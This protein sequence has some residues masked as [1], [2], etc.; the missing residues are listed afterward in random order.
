MGAVLVVRAAPCRPTAVGEAVY[1]HALQVQLLEHDLMT[2]IGPAAGPSGRILPVATNADS[3][4]TWLI[5]ALDELVSS[6]GVRVDVRV[7][8]EDRTAEWLRSGAVL[9]A[10]TSDDRPVQGCRSWPL[11]AMRYR[12]TT[13]PKV[14]ARLPKP[15]ALESWVAV[16]VFGFGTHDRLTERFLRERLGAEQQP[17]IRHHLPSPHAIVQ[18]CERGLGWAMNPE[19]LIVDALETGRLVELSPGATIDVPLCWQ[20]WSLSSETLT[21]VVNVVLRHAQRSLRG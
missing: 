11:G 6:L 16:P 7:E 13:S 19:P 15:S 3:L 21:T 18:A 14:M 12:A 5:P 10:V 2:R 4:A 17:L 9:G 20:Q 8:D 1:R